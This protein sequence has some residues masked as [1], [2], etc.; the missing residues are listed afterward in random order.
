MAVEEAVGISTVCVD[1]LPSVTLVALFGPWSSNDFQ[2][3]LPMQPGG[4]VDAGGSANL[5]LAALVLLSL[6]LASF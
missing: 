6:F 2:T 3:S 1:A 5:F 4:E